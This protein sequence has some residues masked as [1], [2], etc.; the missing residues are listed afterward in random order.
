MI[1]DGHAYCFPDLTKDGGFADPEQ[2]KRHVQVSMAGHFQPVWRKRDRA[3][4]DNSGLADPNIPWS[5]DGLRDSQFRLAGH[6]RM[7]WTAGGED[8]VKQ[9]FPPSIV[10]MSYPAANLVAEMDYAGVDMALLHRTTYLGIGNDFIADCVR[11]FPDRLQGLA[12]VEEWLVQPETDASIKKLARA[13]TEQGLSGLQFLPD[14]MLLYGQSADWDGPGL[15]PFWDA[16][17][18]LNIPLFL[19]P[20]TSY[21]SRAM[22]GGSPAEAVVGQL[23][24]IRGWMERYPDNKV[25][26]THGLSWRMFVG[27][28]SLVIP[29]EVLD[30]VPSDNPNFYV[31]LL[32][33]VLLGGIW[34]Y[35]M[36]QVRP[37][38]EKLVERIGVDRLLW[39]TDMPILMRFWTYKQSLDHMRICGDFLNAD[40]V[41]QI[42]GGNMARL[43]GVSDSRTAHT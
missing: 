9:Y 16:L 29:E 24:K 1:Y 43:M 19:T 3:P 35:P 26:L 25:V 8:Y 28:N 7:E 5:F 18:N 2:F 38:M 39:G 4:G 31:Q 42:V 21:S 14:F 36:L 37:T 41:D 15:C 17:A 27:E 10:D 33:P 23:R 11:L 13:V 34:D 32:F 20:S 40:Q 22:S 30:A 6:G 12:H